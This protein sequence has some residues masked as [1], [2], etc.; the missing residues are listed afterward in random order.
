MIIDDGSTDGSIKLL[1]R[2]KFIDLIKISTNQGKGNAIKKGILSAKYKKILIY[3]GDREL[4][5]RDISK[6]MILNKE[7]KIYGV[8][9]FRFKKL[10]PFKSKDHWGNFIFTTFFNFLYMTFYKDILCCAKS[11]YKEDFPYNKLV[12]KKFDLDVE[13]GSFLTKV[14]KGKTVTQVEI[15][16]IRRSIEDGKKLRTSDGWSILKRIILNRI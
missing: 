9:G 1:E 14:N 16:Y 3:D 11:F 10:N 2:N 8:F 4:R 5:I 15:K 12:S 13:L 7:K 6:L